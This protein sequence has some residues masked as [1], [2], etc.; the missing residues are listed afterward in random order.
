MHPGL[1]VEIGLGLLVDVPVDPD[2]V[3]QP[4]TGDLVVERLAVVA[5][6]GDVERDLRAAR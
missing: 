4:A 1:A 6:A 3:A 2:P 5:L